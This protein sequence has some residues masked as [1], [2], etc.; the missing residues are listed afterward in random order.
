MR[1]LVILPKNWS[2][3]ERI[4]FASF[5][6]F[7]L[8]NVWSVEFF[9]SQDGPAHLYNAGLLNLYHSSD[10]L[11]TY[12]SENVFFLPNYFSHF[13]LSKLCF[14]LD[15]LI[16][17][18]ILL[19]VIVIF[20]PVSFRAATRVLSNNKNSFTFLIFPLVF[21]KLLYMGFFNFT[22]A[23]IFF[24]C[25]LI[26]IN[27]ILTKGFS[28]KTAL[29]L[30][31]NSLLLF[32]SHALIFSLSLIV[33]FIYVVLFFRSDLKLLFKYGFRLLILFLPSLILFSL[34]LFKV[35]VPD[36]NFD[37][38]P[39]QKCAALF[40]FS[41]GTVFD[42]D[43]EQPY[44][45]VISLLVIFLTSY[46]IT[47]RL[48]FKEKAIRLKNDIFLIIALLLIYLIFHS[49]D[50]QFG[51]MFVHRVLFLVFYFLLFWL[52]SN[53]K[54]SRFMLT[55]SLLIVVYSYGKL[56]YARYKTTSG[57][58][59]Q[60]ASVVEAAKFIPPRSVVYTVNYSKTWFHDHVSNYLGLNKEVVLTDNYEAVLG[61]FPLIWRERI[62]EVKFS[63]SDGGAA[64]QPDYLFIYG[65]HRTLND[66]D[67]TEM[68]NF[69]N[70]RAV[71]LFES[72]D[73]FC[74]LYWVKKTS[75][76]KH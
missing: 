32:Y 15:P 29:A 11:K 34:F 35:N 51:G 73:K 39:Y 1:R 9:I 26:L 55:L 71:K 37:L 30:F 17:E 47:Y 18:K 76:Y 69:V 4:V 7:N 19:S 61:W 62:R 64:A 49:K 2:D 12:Y 58:T 6:I 22:L 28:W 54:D 57:A 48:Q 5:L 70:S 43:E 75:P 52:C 59:V 41:P 72:Q 16:S 33:T 31:A 13:V 68:R 36:Y 63:V 8:I 25:H 65:K 21:S 66:P 60:A 10:F 56:S 27:R 45:Y 67:N 53:L 23:F 74:T 46:V 14:F 40:S 24:N 3:A 44:T 42:I 50:G 38:K 20:L